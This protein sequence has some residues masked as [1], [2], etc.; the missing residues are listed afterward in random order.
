MAELTINCK[1]PSF[2]SGV[3]VSQLLYP[4]K[5]LL[6]KI[7]PEFLSLFKIL[8]RLSLNDVANYSNNPYT[9]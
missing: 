5:F 8:G 7:V 4:K 1:I 2:K 9:L 3:T 6:H